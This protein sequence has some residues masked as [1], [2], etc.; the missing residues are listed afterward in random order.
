MGSARKFKR[1]FKK[2]PLSFIDKA[3]Y[4]ILIFLGVVLAFVL[5][6]LF[7]IYIPIKMS[8]SDVNVVA[9]VNSSAT[10]WAMPFSLLGSMVFV[11]LGYF[12]LKNK[13]PIFGNKKIKP[14]YFESTIKTYPLFSKGFRENLTVSAARKIRITAISI[15]IAIVVSAFMIP[16]GFY[17]RTVLDKD[18]N[19]ITYNTFNKETKRINIS[20]S[21]KNVINISY[22]NGRRSGPRWGIQMIFVFDNEEYTV[23]LGAFD[24]MSTSEAL[25]YMI[26]LKNNLGEGNYTITN[27][28][29]MEDL[30]TQNGYS[31]EEKALIYEL[32]EYKNK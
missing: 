30:L 25:R 32:F 23:G 9:I 27:T 21:Q 12:G 17:P 5:F 18:N 4:V 22:S 10:I 1:K 3:I 15:L 6:A 31:D 28:N 24:K 16:F 29:R 13:Q 11:V 8:Y 7:G 2:A 26:D 20:D 14:S 19:I